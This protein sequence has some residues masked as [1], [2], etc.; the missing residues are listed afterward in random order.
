MLS[1]LPYWCEMWKSIKTPIYFFPIFAGFEFL[2]PTVREICQIFISSDTISVTWI[3]LF[4]G[5]IYCCSPIAGWCLFVLLTVKK[6][7]RLRKNKKK[8][9]KKA[10]SL[11][12]S[13]YCTKNTMNWYKVQ[14]VVV[15]CVGIYTQFPHKIKRLTPYLFMFI[16]LGEKYFSKLEKKKG[17]SKFI[18]VYYSWQDICHPCIFLIGVYLFVS[19]WYFSPRVVN[20][21]VRRQL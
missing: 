17:G 12:N 18:V 9:K 8:R 6:E 11:L 10:W 3:I 2:V 1:T 14:A 19:N 21:K 5:L 15:L 4:V 13:V 7:I 20:N 16:N